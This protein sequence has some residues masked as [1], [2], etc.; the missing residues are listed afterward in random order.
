[1]NKVIKKLQEAKCDALGL[2]R[3]V[4]AFH[5]KLLQKDWHEQFSTMDI[6]AKLSVEIVKTGIL[7]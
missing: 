2:G 3:N 5:P 4:R 6:S 7:E 1:M